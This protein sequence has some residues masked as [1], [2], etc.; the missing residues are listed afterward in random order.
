MCRL[1]CMVNSLS[2][3][4]NT[5]NEYGVVILFGGGGDTPPLFIIIKI[6]CTCCPRW[7]WGAKKSKNCPPRAQISGRHLFSY[8]FLNN[9]PILINF[10]CLKAL[11]LVELHEHSCNSTSARAT[12]RAPVQLH[13]RSC[14]SKS[15][16]RAFKQKKI[17]Q[18]QTIIK[19]VTSKNVILHIPVCT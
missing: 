9:G 10:F 17:D 2:A 8:N 5:G 7:Q 19:E 13:E 3:C 4:G 16:S 11:E 18:N 15:S 14:N 1:T 6:I 12:P